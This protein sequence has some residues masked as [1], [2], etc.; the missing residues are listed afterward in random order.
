VT[1]PDAALV[2]E[3]IA[4]IEP[5]GSNIYR[6]LLDSLRALADRMEG[7]GTVSRKGSHAKLVTPGR[8]VKQRLVDA[9]GR[10]L[11]SEMEFVDDGTVRLPLDEMQRLVSAWN[12]YEAA[13][14]DSA[15]SAHDP[16][17]PVAQTVGYICLPCHHLLS[18]FDYETLA[19]R[20]CDHQWDAVALASKTGLL[21]CQR[22]NGAVQV[23]CH[24]CG[25]TP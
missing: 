11:R 24:D 4:V 7:A 12:L 19:N 5:T 22:C 23:V 10:L 1:N 18:V 15:L 2:R 25:D 14:D 6:D 17:P 16:T 8:V 3:A 13:R 21:R 20:G 9:V